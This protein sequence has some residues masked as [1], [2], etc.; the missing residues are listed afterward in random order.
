MFMLWIISVFKNGFT[1]VLNHKWKTTTFVWGE[2]D[3]HIEKNYDNCDNTYLFYHDP[4][5][6]YGPI[7]LWHKVK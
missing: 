5:S 6:L 3:A 2:G 4:N 1:K 7:M